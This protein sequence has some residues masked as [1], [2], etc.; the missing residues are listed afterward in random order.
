VGAR[1]HLLSDLQRLASDG[2][3]SLRAHLPPQDTQAE[4]SAWLFRQIGQSRYEARMKRAI[5][6]GVSF[7]LALATTVGIAAA[8][9]QQN[10]AETPDNPLGTPWTRPQATYRFQNPGLPTYV[11][12][13][14]VHAAPG[15]SNVIY[16]NNC[17]PNGCPIKPG[18]A[19]SLT[20]TS[21]IPQQQS[22]V[23]AWAYSDA[24]WNQVVACVR[25]TYA[26][27]GV[28]IVDERPGAGTNYHMGIVAGRPGDVQMQNGVG[29]VS[30]FS[31]GYIPNAISFSFA[32]IYGPDVDQ[33]CWTVAQETAHSWGLDHK[34]DNRD[35]M[36][37]LSSGP[38]RKAFRNED[39][40][41]GEFSARACQCGGSKMNSF[42]EILSTFGSGTPTP[43]TVTITAPA[44]KESGLEAGFPIRSDATDDAGIAKVE[45]RI[46]GQLISSLNNAPYVW[47]APATLGQGNHIIKVTAYDISGTPADATVTAALG[48]ACGSPSDC[49]NDTDTCVDGRCVPSGDV[50]GG[51]GTT[52]MN[53]TDCV[54]GQCGA[55]SAGDHF[56]VETCD[57]AQNGCPSGFGCLPSGASGVCWPGADSGEGGI[58]SAGGNAAPGFLFI[59]LV[60]LLV[61]RRRR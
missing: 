42:A 3:I 32:N 37:Y 34:F 39:G 13:D 9:V 18:N 45:L 54:S 52:C 26:P 2:D 35:P 1:A 40:P 55:D 20:N 43:P 4:D 51:L 56:C 53:N 46:D 48:M 49:A 5:F 17:K 41:C 58:C 10:P 25:E 19:N 60:A 29:G 36:T 61:T 27:F 6:G 50:T 28:Q 23:A 16:L 44:N 57:P 47:N 59:G 12:P 30:E 21:G 7:V 38:S 31:C 24:V 8:D 14:A 22:T 33:I 15:F 11:G